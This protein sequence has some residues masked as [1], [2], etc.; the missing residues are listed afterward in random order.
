MARF[1][2][3]KMT[4]IGDVF[5]P[6]RGQSYDLS[7]L[8][9]LNSGIDTIK[10]L[11]NCLPDSKILDQLAIHFDHHDSDVVKFGGLEW[12]FKKAG[13]TSGYQYILKNLEEG[14][15]VLLKS[16]YTEYNEHGAH[17]KIEATPQI[18]DELGLCGV[19]RRIRE[20]GNIFGTSLEASGVAVHLFTDMK[21]LEI[22]EDFEMK[23][24][25]RAKR[26]LKVGAIS[27]AHFEAAAAS[28][29]YGQNDT[30]TFGQASSLQMCLYDKTKE[31]E[32]SGKH[33][34]MTECWLRTPS[35]QDPM[36]PEYEYGDTVHR[37]EFRVHQKIIKEFEHGNFNK[38][39]VLDNKGRVIKQGDMV[40]IREARDLKKHLQGLWE[41]CLENFRLEESRTYV[42]P[43]WQKLKEDVKY[44][45]IHPTFIYARGKQK[46]LGKVSGRNI[47]MWLG[48]YIRVCSEIRLKPEVVTNIICNSG[49]DRYLFDYF[50]L[51]SYGDSDLLY[52]AVYDFVD[53]RMTD[54]RLNGVAA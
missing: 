37:L 12:K 33:D 32:V 9:I 41:Y 23:L 48:N 7:C 6:E 30:Y 31:M 8:K 11:F 19:S 40:H 16:F 44:F 42:H 20:I 35:T 49:V 51:L 29:V 15:V 24:A 13:S 28:F 22:P 2:N 53:K 34:F 46:T 21:G 38:T 25:C 50:S 1:Q 5:T 14:F 45:D 39:Q 54:H 43:I 36:L 10:Q 27:H 17:L 47:G 52:Q 18:I 26:A 3:K 4:R